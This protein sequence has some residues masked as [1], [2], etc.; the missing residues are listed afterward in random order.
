MG[1]APCVVCH[2]DHAVMRTS[3]ALVG[4]DAQAVCV[5][6]HEAKSAGFKQAATMRAFLDG[7]REAIARATAVLDQA[8][9][10]GMEIS[11]ARFELR[12]AADTLLKARVAIHL[13]DPAAIQKLTDDGKQVAAATQAKGVKALEDLAFR[14]RGL[15]ISVGI[16]LLVIVGLVLKIREM[17]RRKDQEPTG[18]RRE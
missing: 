15:W 5:S 14:R 8:E 18:G 17:D 4:T 3:D 10:A 9:H 12:G 6:C 11:Q 2:S 16:I 1:L 13:V 7:L